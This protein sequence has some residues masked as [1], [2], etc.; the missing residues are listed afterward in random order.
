[1]T[2]NTSFTAELETII[3]IRCT[4]YGF[5]FTDSGYCCCLAVRCGLALISIFGCLPLISH[6]LKTEF[7]EIF[8][9]ILMILNEIKWASVTSINFKSH[10]TNFQTIFTSASLHYTAVNNPFRPL[11]VKQQTFYSGKQGDEIPTLGFTYSCPG[12]TNVK[13][14]VL[15]SNLGFHI[16]LHL[17][18]CCQELCSTLSFFL[19]R[20]NCCQ[21]MNFK[22]LGFLSRANRCR[23]LSFLTLGF[24]SS[25]QGQIVV[26]RWILKPWVSYQGQTVAGSWVF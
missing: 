22:T 7:C 2:P 9:Y 4:V 16:T 21:E 18:N 19:S 23:E 6:C 8:S 11:R 3:Y 12:Q 24:T 13:S 10:I 20:A 15:Y 5:Y 1:V 26:K 17:A 14:W 25:C